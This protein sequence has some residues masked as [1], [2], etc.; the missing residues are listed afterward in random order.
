MADWAK[1]NEP[2]R[3]LYHQPNSPNGD[4]PFAHVYGVRYR[5]PAELERRVQASTKPVVMGE[6]AHA[7]GNGLGN[8][9]QFWALT[10]KYPQLQGGF[11]WDWAEANLK[12]PLVLTPDSSRSRIQAFLVGKVDRA[13]GRRGQAVELSGLDDYVNTFRDPRL[14]VAGTALTLDAWVKPGLWSGSF[15]IL[16]KGQ[17]YG[18]QMRDERTLEFGV[19]TG[20][21]QVVA[22]AVPADWY[23]NWHRVTGVYDGTALRLY[24]DGRSA[25]DTPHTGELRPGLYEVNVGRNAETQQESLRTWLGRGLVDD[26]RVY[27]VALTAAQLSAGADPAAAAVLALDFDRYVERGEFASLGISLSGTDGLVGTDRYLQPETVQLAWAQAPV[28]FTAVDVAAGKVRVHNEQQAGALDLR[29]DWSLAEVS[30]VLK[31]G[32]RPLRLEPGQTVDLDLGAAP[33]NPRDVERW[34]NVVAVAARALPWA[35][36]GWRLGYDQFPAGGRLVPGVQLPPS[37]APVPRVTDTD[38]RVVVAGSGWMY[39][40]DKTTGTLSSMDGRGGELLRQ[41]PR[42]DVYRPPTSNETFRW[43]TADREIWQARPGPTPHRSRTADH[44]DR[45]R[46]CRD[47]RSAQ[48][49]RRT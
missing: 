36:R 35:P 13:P 43:G 21:R 9:D 25:A 4:A 22:A 24:I 38:T 23:G 15:P 44:V 3:L 14:D 30:R 8:F 48:H 18:L 46:R 32:S 45:G 19:E 5:A 41:G 16:T 10:R 47:G 39:T 40:F 1:A 31:S 17:Q 6:Y 29:L 49:R 27:P 26:V 7:Q 12:Q 33:A 2:T 20:T 34:L 37:T 42:L 11:V 28:R